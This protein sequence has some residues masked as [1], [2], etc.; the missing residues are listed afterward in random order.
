MFFPKHNMQNLS[1]KDLHYK[2]TN[3]YNDFMQCVCIVKPALVYVWM[4]PVHVEEDKN[5]LQFHI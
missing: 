3:G 4:Q 5:Q 1:Q 2:C